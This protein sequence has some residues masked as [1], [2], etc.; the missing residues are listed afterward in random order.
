MSDGKLSITTDPFPLVVSI[1]DQNLRLVT[2]LVSPTSGIKLPEGRYYVQA[3]RPLEADLRAVAEVKGGAERTI[4]LAAG[5][6]SWLQRINFRNAA[7]PM[8]EGGSAAGRELRAT[9]A[10]ASEPAPA[11]E[12]V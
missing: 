10:A 6:P 1:F 2:Q 4:H 7:V 11:L 5:D 8:L 9:S 12:P 3:S